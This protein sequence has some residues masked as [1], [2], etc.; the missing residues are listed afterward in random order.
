MAIVKIC[1]FNFSIYGKKEK[2]EKNLKEQKWDEVVT[3]YGH[4]CYFKLT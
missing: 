2:N 1:E 4:I 3:K